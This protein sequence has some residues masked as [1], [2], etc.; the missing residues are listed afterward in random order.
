MIIAIVI[1]YH[2]TV[3]YVFLVRPSMAETTAL[4]VALAAGS[5]EGVDV[6]DLD[7]MTPPPADTF[8]TSITNDGEL[9]CVIV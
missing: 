6:W 9:L 8:T 1:Y 7:S 3:N 5:A 4:G 2:L